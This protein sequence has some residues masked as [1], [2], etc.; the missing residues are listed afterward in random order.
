M[1]LIFSYSG[2]SEELTEMLRFANRFGV[3]VI[4]IASSKES[5]LLKASD[6]KLLIPKVKEADITSIVPTSSTTITLV[7]GDSLCAAIQHKKKFSKAENFKFSK[8]KNIEQLNFKPLF[9]KNGLIFFDNLGSVSYTHL[10]LPTNRE[11]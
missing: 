8:F 2:N 1:L 4:G 11:V 9:L 6:I 10:T 7:L 3:R 5:N